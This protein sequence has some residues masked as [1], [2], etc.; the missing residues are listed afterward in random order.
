MPQRRERAA[1]YVRE[2]DVTLAMDS[3]TIESAVKALL[4]HCQKKGYDVDPSHIYREAISGYHVYYFDRPELMRALKAVQ[5]HEFDVLLVTEIRALSRR[6]AGEV[7]VIYNILQKANVRLETLS[8]TIT[9]DPMGEVLLTFRATWARIER[10]QSFIRMQRGKRDRIEI[11]KAPSNGHKCYGYVLVDTVKEVKGRYEFDTA[12]IHRDRNGEEW[13]TIKVRKFILDCLTEGETLHS[14]SKKLNDLGVPPAGKA[15][16]GEGCWYPLTVRRI[17]EQP[18]NRGDVYAN[19][20]K[21]VPTGKTTPDGRRTYKMVKR[22]EEEWILLPPGT[23]PALISRERHEAIMKQLAYNK[24]E[25][26]RNN[27]H[28]AELGLLRGGYIFCGICDKRMTVRYKDNNGKEKGKLPPYYRCYHKEGGAGEL[29]HNHRTQIHMRLIDEVVKEKIIAVLKQPEEVRKKV[30]AIR[31]ANKPKTTPQ[32]IEETIAAIKQSMQNLY[33]LAERAT[34]DETI[35]DLAEKMNEREQQKR[36]AE[37]MLHVLADDAEERAKV[38]KEVQKFEAWAA[39]VQPFLTDKAYMVQASY[40]ELRL[41]IRILGI[42]VIVYPTI[43]D[44]PFR[45]QVDVTVPEVIAQ[46][47]IVC[48]S[49]CTS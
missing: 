43:G 26:L 32:E 25:S 1:L 13:S 38:E 11:G 33:K 27:H 31:Q 36:E 9:D 49:R 45:Y 48:Q 10:E 24:Q 4:D 29:I 20:Y 22:P 2:S 3:T 37:K 15:K 39:S 19:Q 47:N 18:I 8:E 12:V 34:D 46:M 44:Y 23:A 40:A 5:R 30:A 41:A 17:A 6:G 28:P 7:L 14:I 16:K 42:R 21:K 35:A